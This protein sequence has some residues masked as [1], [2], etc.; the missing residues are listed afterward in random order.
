M[1]K[2]LIFGDSVSWE[3]FDNEKGGWFERLKNY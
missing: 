1:I 2:I 3:A